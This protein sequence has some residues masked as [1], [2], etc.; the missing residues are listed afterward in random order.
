MHPFS[1][2][3]R[4]RGIGFRATKPKHRCVSD[5]IRKDWK[6]MMP[7]VTEDE[8]YALLKLLPCEPYM[9]V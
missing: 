4:S 1:R 8:P 2:L 6:R 3:P 9:Q 5:Y 7:G